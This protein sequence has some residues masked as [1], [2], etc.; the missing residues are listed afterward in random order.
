MI[1]DRNASKRLLHPLCM[2]SSR[3]WMRD[4]Q[5]YGGVDRIHIPQA[6][7]ISALSLITSPFRIAERALFKKRID[8][9]PIE[10]PPIFILG[11]WRTGTTFL[12]NLLTQDKNLGHVSLFQTLAPGAFFLGR[13]TFQP[14][15][16]MRA[17]DTRPMDNVPIRMEGPQ[18]EEFAMAHYSGHSFYTG[19]YFPRKME[20]L[21]DKY[22]LFDGLN[23]EEHE[24]W[25]RAYLY[26]LRA[27]TLRAKGK[28]LVLKNPVNTCRIS[29]L[30]DLF[31]DAKFVHICRDPYAVFKSSLHLYRSVLDLV[32]LQEIDDAQ[33]ERYVLKF[34]RLMLRRYLEERHLIPEGNLVEVRYENL[35]R[36]PLHEIERVYAELGLPGWE[37]AGGD[38]QAYA[39][40]QRTYKK[41]VYTRN[42]ADCEKVETHWEF[43]LDA[44]GYRHPAD[45]PADEFLM[46]ASAAER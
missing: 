24:E 43:A 26:V 28:R 6:A 21:F 16:A 22:A 27:A 36:E 1:L 37:G 23:E 10:H 12:H 18:E 3:L 13:P 11:H 33:I 46:D 38:I 40:S 34:Y 29:A 44:W 35:D 45:V 31:P 32:S 17:P 4:L 2:N 9:T 14:L 19:W 15:A 42:A 7:T 39:E 8:S 30:L 20:Q 25:R 41:N 5:R